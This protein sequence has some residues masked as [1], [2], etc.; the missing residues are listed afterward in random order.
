MMPLL[1]GPVWPV[2][3]SLA[4]AAFFGVGILLIKRGLAHHDPAT[5]AMLSIGAASAV[6]WLLAP[7]YL[8]WSYW[9]SPAMLIFAGIGLVRP[10]VSATLA[11]M[12]THALGPTIS[13]TV[14]SVSPLVAVAGGV[15]LLGEAATPPIALGTLAIVAGVILLSWKG[16]TPR[17]WST[18]ALGFPMGAATIRALAHVFGKMGLNILP[19][20]LTAGLI[21]NTVSF[22][23]AFAVA[24]GRKGRPL[25]SVR[26]EG[27]RWFLA[28][29]CCNA[30]A[31]MSLNTA[32]LLGDVVMVSPIVASS[33]LF[34]MVFSAAFMRSERLT[35]RIV[36]AVLLV[37]PGVMLVSAFR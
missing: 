16:R 31:I 32:L 37:V 5:G 29:G 21:G 25:D 3:M 8:E 1:E 33:P 4:A 26:W 30:G 15:L 24:T 19:S 9:A 28:A 11:N 23:V 20:P 18:L 7:L 2:A 14:A 36:A 10:V 17:T 13:A 12:G 22:A 34:T 27:A 35:L 6:H